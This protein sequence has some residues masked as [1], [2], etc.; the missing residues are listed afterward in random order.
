[1]GG[2]GRTEVVE[3]EQVQGLFAMELRLLR[4]PKVFHGLG[5]RVEVPFVQVRME[6]ER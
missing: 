3:D 6:L 1:M 5:E 2:H 4:Q